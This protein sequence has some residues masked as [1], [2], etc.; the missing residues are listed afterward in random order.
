MR[1]HRIQKGNGRNVV[2]KTQ[3]NS[4]NFGGNEECG[5]NDGK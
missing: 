1:G 3:R 2:G 4:V 5:T